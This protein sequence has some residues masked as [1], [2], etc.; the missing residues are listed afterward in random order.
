MLY[1]VITIQ[2]LAADGQYRVEA[3]HRVLEDHGDLV[4]T[5]GAHLFVIDARITSYN[6][7]YTKLLRVGT[8]FIEVFVDTPLEVVEERDVKGW[9]AKA[10]SAAM[11]AS[12]G[13]CE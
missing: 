7:C 11:R 8:D 12:I 3:G 6:V 2:L 9:Y 13:G 1:E 10:R 5:Q 4:A